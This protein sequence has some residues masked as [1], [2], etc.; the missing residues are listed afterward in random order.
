MSLAV[1]DA[2]RGPGT[3]GA[4]LSGGIDSSS[5]AVIAQRDLR[6]RGDGL[7]GLFSWSPAPHGA[8]APDDERL[9]VLAVARNLGVGVTFADVLESDH[10]LMARWR[11]E[12][13]PTETLLRELSIQ[14]AARE[15][16]VSV[17][18]SGWGGDELASFNGRGHLAWLATRGRWATI[19]RHLSRSSRRVASSPRWRMRAALTELSTGL[20]PLLPST[21]RDRRAAAHASAQPTADD[22]RVAQLRRD[23]QARGRDRVGGRETQLALLRLGHLTVRIEAWARAGATVGIEYRYPLLDRRVVELCLAFPEHLWLHEGFTRWVYRAAVHP[24]LPAELTWGIPKHEP[25]LRGPPE[26]RS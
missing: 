2:V 20:E 23:R 5:L 1:A 14:R 16:G 18:L 22:A 13:V 11:E 9:R 26:S 24:L 15:L 19:L 6:A 3:Y 10:E 8:L 25:G 17:M 12:L 21:V 7:R 4:H